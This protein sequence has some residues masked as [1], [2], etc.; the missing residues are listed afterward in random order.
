[1]FCGRKKMFEE[2]DS[3]YKYSLCQINQQQ[4]STSQSQRCR[5]NPQQRCVTQ[6]QTVCGG[7]GVRYIGD[8]IPAVGSRYYVK[9]ESVPEMTRNSTD[10]TGKSATRQDPVKRQVVPTMKRN[11][12]NTGTRIRTVIRN[13]NN[14]RKLTGIRQVVGNKQCSSVPRKVCSTDLKR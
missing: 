6:Y 10:T 5:E 1:M 8:N 9:R 3:I 2:I 14:G 4:C 11:I 7:S 12:T 13:R